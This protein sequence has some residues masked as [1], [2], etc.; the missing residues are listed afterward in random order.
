MTIQQSYMP[1][2]IPVHEKLFLVAKSIGMKNVELFS[3]NT[4]SK[5]TVYVKKNDGSTGPFELVDDPREYIPVAGEFKVS[6]VWDGPLENVIATMPTTDGCRIG[7]G[8]SYGDAILNC[9]YDYFSRCKN[10]AQ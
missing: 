4:S 9:L 5:K 10:H 8:K 7:Y 6:F 1:N 3:S 2:F